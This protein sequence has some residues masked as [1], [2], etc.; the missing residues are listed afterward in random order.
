M[1]FNNVQEKYRSF[2]TSKRH[3]QT[4]IL[5]I[6]KHSRTEI[7]QPIYCSWIPKSYWNRTAYILFMK[8]NLVLKSHCLYTVYEYQTRSEI[9]QPIFCLWI[10]ISYWN[11]RAY[12]LFMNTYLDLK[13]QSL[14]TVHEKICRTEVT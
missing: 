13:L 7:A 2:T 6:I 14:Y 8:T 11:C 5:F 10:P 4:Y 3:R 12:I 9:E 1:N